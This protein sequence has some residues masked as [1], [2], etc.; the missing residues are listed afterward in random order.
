MGAER[1]RPPACVR[2][3]RV[4]AAASRFPLCEG[5]EPRETPSPG[6]CHD[7]ILQSARSRLIGTLARTP[8]SAEHATLLRFFPAWIHGRRVVDSWMDFVE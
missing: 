2:C 6:A 1:L 7:A 4:R 5:A 3:I 8:R